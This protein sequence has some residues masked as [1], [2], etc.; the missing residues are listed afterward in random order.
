MGQESKSWPAFRYLVEG[1]EIGY[2]IWLPWNQRPAVP[3]SL[4]PR[5]RRVPLGFS[6]GP[7]AASLPPYLYP[8]HPLVLGPVPLV[9]I[10][11][12][13]CSIPDGIWSAQGLPYIWAESRRA[14]AWHQGHCHRGAAWL[15]LV[16]QVGLQDTW[17]E[18]VP[19]WPLL[20]CS[21]GRLPGG[22][23]FLCACEGS[24]VGSCLGSGQASGSRVVALG[25]EQ[26]KHLGSSGPPQLFPGDGAP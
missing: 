4:C 5:P 14:E 12:A 23:F 22:A 9:G 7:L 8:G 19:G 13:S 3:S 2:V 20:A 6:R 18:K 11:R 10:K 24:K 25:I 1:V 26:R 15:T 21:E 16:V 17:T